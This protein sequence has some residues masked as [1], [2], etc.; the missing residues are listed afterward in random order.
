MG[1]SRVGGNGFFWVKLN[2]DVYLDGGGGRY[3]FFSV[4]YKPLFKDGGLD[5]IYLVNY[6][7]IWRLNYAQVK[8]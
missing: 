1:L 8:I 3:D 2:F 5:V 4:I 6:D 7:P